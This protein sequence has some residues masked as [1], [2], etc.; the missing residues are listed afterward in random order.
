MDLFKDL[1]TLLARNIMLN[2]SVKKSVKIG[3]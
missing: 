2:L 3:E 1:F